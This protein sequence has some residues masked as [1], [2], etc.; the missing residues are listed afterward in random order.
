MD[1]AF[2]GAYALLPE[3]RHHFDGV[4]GCD[5]FSTNAHKVC[6]LFSH[7]NIVHLM[8]AIMPGTRIRHHLV[9]RVPTG[10]LK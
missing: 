4:D 5:S 9:A 8:C 3:L 10:L 2:A 6:R 1:A 7:P